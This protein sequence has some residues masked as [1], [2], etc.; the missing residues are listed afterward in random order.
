MADIYLGFDPGGDRRFGVALLEGDC[1]TTS[2]ISSVADA[3]NWAVQECGQRQP[4]AAGIDTL[5]HWTTTRS[6]LRPCD[7]KLRADYPAVQNSVMALNSL[8]G[9]MAIGGMA[10]AL[11]LRQVWPEIVLN[12]THPKVLMHALGAEKY[13]PQTVESKRQYSG[14][15]RKHVARSGSFAMSTSLMPLSPHGPHERG[16]P[17]GGETSPAQAMPFPFPPDRCDT[18]GRVRH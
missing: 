6:G 17:K 2:T 7:L 14:S 13:T 15:S 8:F 11:R 12:E 10:L 4:I 9:A 5:L 1:V 18:C 16:S 3:I